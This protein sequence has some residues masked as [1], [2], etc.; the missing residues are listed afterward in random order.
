MA[1]IIIDMLVIFKSIYADKTSLKCHTRIINSL[2][3]ILISKC[4]EI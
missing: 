4:M 2:Q 1:L 3:D